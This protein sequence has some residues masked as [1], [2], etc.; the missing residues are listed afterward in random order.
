MLGNSW[1]RSVSMWFLPSNNFD[2]K[3]AFKT[4]FNS[5]LARVLC[6]KHFTCE[7]RSHIDKIMGCGHAHILGELILL[8][9]YGFGKQ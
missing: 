4:V 9:P 3:M 5:Y 7:T 8:L 1:I 2:F 6:W